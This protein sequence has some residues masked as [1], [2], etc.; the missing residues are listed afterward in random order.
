MILPKGIRISS[1]YGER[2]HPVTNRKVFHNGID[3][4]M[5]IGTLIVAPLRGKIDKVWEDEIGGLQMRYVCAL[6]G[7][8]VWTLGFAHLSRVVGVE[9]KFY[10]EGLS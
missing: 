3:L 1:N 9:G 6:I 5:P 10:N 2:I 4:V 7:N 8:D